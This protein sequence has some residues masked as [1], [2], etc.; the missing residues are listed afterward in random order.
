L[1]FDSKTKSSRRQRTEGKKFSL[2][3][4]LQQQV[5]TLVRSESLP[6]PRVRSFGGVAGADSWFLSPSVVLLVDDTMH[7]VS[8]GLAKFGMG[9]S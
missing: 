5:F 2:G 9:L 3:R 8:E 6:A 4:N 1:H 7:A